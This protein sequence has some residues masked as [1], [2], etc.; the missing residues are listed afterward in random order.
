MIPNKLN[1]WAC[2]TENWRD[3]RFIYCIAWNK[4]SNLQTSCKQFIRVK[5]C[6]EKC[7]NICRTWIIRQRVAALFYT[8]CFIENI[9]NHLNSKYILGLSN[10]SNSNN[11]RNRVVLPQIKVY[12]WNILLHLNV[13]D[14]CWWKNVCA[15]CGQAFR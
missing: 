13:K 2:K 6:V 15:V 7:R 11:R 1:C 5:L 10:R 8:K 12:A 14:A 4:C 3:Y 9:T